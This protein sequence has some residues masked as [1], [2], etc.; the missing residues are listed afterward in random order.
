MKDEP[1][2]SQ[3]LPITEKELDYNPLPKLNEFKV[4]TGKDI[5]FHCEVKQING[6]NY[7]SAT[8][9]IDNV[10]SKLS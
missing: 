6:C 1:L 9:F 7:N 2:E 8:L 10:L 4:A 3:L 5:R